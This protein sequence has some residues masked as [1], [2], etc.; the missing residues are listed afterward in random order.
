M[1][2][3]HQIDDDSGDDVE[4]MFDKENNTNID[5]NDDLLYQIIKILLVRTLFRITVCV[6]NYFN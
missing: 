6:I 5:D 1:S 4:D 2:I 3:F